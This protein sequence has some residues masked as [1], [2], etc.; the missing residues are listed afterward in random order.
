M[1][2]AAAFFCTEVLPELPARGRLRRVVRAL[3][4]RAADP[5]LRDRAPSEFVGD[6]YCD[7]GLHRYDGE[8][9]DF[10][11]PELGCDGATASP[12]ASLGH[13]GAVRHA[14]PT[15]G[16]RRQVD[17]IASIQNSTLAGSPLH[18]RR[19]SPRHHALVHVTSWA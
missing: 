17:T 3:R 19:P 13:E 10:N 9:I 15:S 8:L 4:R 2:V 12:S 5:R 7:A 1:S 6:G 11:C 14:A 18:G 16:R